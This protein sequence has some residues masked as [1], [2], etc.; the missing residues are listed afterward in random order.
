VGGCATSHKLVSARHTPCKYSE[1]EISQESYA[2]EEET[3]VATCG[4]RTY[5]C[6]T[7]AIGNRVQ[8]R[9]RPREQSSLHQK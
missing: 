7:Q 3:W 6:A 4:D 1:I 2:A 8:Y 9:C 5:D